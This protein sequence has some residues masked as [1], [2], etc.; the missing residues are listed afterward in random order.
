LLG[1]REGLVW[2]LGCLLALVA[3]IQDPFDW[4]PV[5]AYGTDFRIRFIATFTLVSMISFWF[6]YLRHS[7]F[8]KM[9]DKQAK[10]EQERQRL[11]REIEQRQAAERA[12]QDV[13]LDLQ[14]ALEKVKTLSGLIPICASCH[15]IRDDEGFWDQMES[16]I[17]RHSDVQFSHGICPDCMTRLYPEYRRAAGGE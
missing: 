3:L 10:L 4:V 5:Y 7:Y 1:T 11:E 13:I 12:K 14:A 2:S 6:Q 9:E 8:V 16:Y 15:K 17:G